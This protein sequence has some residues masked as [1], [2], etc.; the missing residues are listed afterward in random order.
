MATSEWKLTLSHRKPNGSTESRPT[1]TWY[2]VDEAEARK[3]WDFMKSKNPLN[4]HGYVIRISRRHTFGGQPISFLW[5]IQDEVSKEANPGVL[6]D[7]TRSYTNTDWHHR[8][9]DSDEEEGPN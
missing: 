8:D 5:V 3:S 4:K 6:G 7:V 2:F 1:Y 9:E